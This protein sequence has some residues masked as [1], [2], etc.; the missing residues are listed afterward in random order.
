MRENKGCGVP[1]CLVDVSSEVWLGYRL[2]KLISQRAQETQSRRGRPLGPA[3][4]AGGTGTAERSEQW[5]GF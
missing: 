2:E 1:G 5:I 3:C 4:K